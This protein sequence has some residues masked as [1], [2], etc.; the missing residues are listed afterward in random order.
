MYTCTRYLSGGYASR[1]YS[2]Y[3]N[4]GLYA[5]GDTDASAYRYFL[6]D[7][8]RSSDGSAWSLITEAAFQLTPQSLPLG[9]GGHQMLVVTDANDQP[10]LWVIAGRGGD[11]S[12]HGTEMVI[13][14]N[15][16]HGDDNDESD[17]NNDMDDH[18][19]V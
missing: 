8:W 13:C 10:Q 4:C 12:V 1:L 15:D 3:S 18:G 11:N 9:R 16:D 6:S 5:C 7:V 2:Q 17:Y 14:D 19:N